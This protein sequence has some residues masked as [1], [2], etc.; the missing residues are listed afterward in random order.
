MEDPQLEYVGFWARVGAALIDTVLIM[1]VTAPLLTAIYGTAYWDG[2]ALIKGPTD[3]LLS[4]VFPAVA[5]IVF[6]ITRQATPGKMAVAARI[7]DADTGQPIGRR[8]AVIRYLGYYVAM[9][10]LFL[11]I[12]WVAFDSRKQGWHDKLANTVVVRRKGPPTASFKN[13]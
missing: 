7:V 8:Q 1:M 4:W 9:L 12:F 11:G 5:V 3:F 6:W 2:G 13:G 10:P